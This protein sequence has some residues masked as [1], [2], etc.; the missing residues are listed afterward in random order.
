MK[1]GA[2][3]WWRGAFAAAVG[4][5]YAQPLFA[6]DV[7]AGWEGSAGRG[8]AFVSPS[9]TWIRVGQ[10]SGILR[11]AASYLYYD[12]PDT[13]G[14]T[15][16]SSPGQSIGLGLRYTAPGFTATIGPGYEVRQTRRRFAAGGYATEHE[17]GLTLDGNVFVQAT[18]RTAISLL[19]SYGKANQYYWV[20]G[21]IKQQIGGFEGD[22]AVTWHL[23]AELTSQGNQDVTARQLGGVLEA[24]FPRGQ[25]SLQLHAGASRRE[26]SDVSKASSPY[27]GLGFY[28][29]F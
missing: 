2:C 6:Q 28:R 26:N 8:Y 5:V 21:G 29:G 12:L 16:V 22:S 14:K 27:F 3:I 18:S 25:G 4:L 15:T 11:G 13:G 10:V 24:A 1:I 20:R 19:G 23:G 7:V 17:R 9:M